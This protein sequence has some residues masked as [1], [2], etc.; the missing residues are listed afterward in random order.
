MISREISEIVRGFCTISFAKYVD[1]MFVQIFVHVIVYHLRSGLDA[2]TAA[3]LAE[4]ISTQNLKEFQS[5]IRPTTGSSGT[6]I[7]SNYSDCHTQPRTHQ[8][9]VRHTQRQSCSLR[10]N[11]FEMLWKGKV[12]SMKGFVCFSSSIQKGHL[13]KDSRAQ[14]LAPDLWHIRINQIST[15]LTR[16]CDTVAVV[17]KGQVVQRGLD[18]GIQIYCKQIARL[19]SRSLCRVDQ[20]CFGTTGANCQATSERAKA[21]RKPFQRIFKEFRFQRC[22]KIDLGFN[23]SNYILDGHCTLNAIEC[24]TL[25]RWNEAKN[26]PAFSTDEITTIT[27]NIK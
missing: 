19:H 4:A 17:S 6:R 22:S 24:H 27:I 3:S 7:S 23:V 2:N 20:R 12:R 8:D 21:W 5:E 15:V 26:W 14:F 11:E 9:R 10:L 16:S 18:L 1:N 25:K 13:E